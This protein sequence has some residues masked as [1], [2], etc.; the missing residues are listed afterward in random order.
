VTTSDG[1][2]LA[3]ARQPDALLQLTA[4]VEELAV[5]VNALVE[6]LS[7]PALA[8]P[9]LMT[10]AQAGAV[11]GV[12]PSWVRGEAQGGRIT[13]RRV[14]AQYRF[15]RDDVD[16]LIEKARRAGA[17]PYVR[18]AQQLAA[19]NRRRVTQPNPP[20]RQVGPHDRPRDLSPEAARFFEEHNGPLAGIVCPGS[21]QAATT[22][23]EYGWNCPSCDSTTHS[24]RRGSTVLY[25]HVKYVPAG[26]E[27]ARTGRLWP[28]KHPVDTTRS[29][30]AP[31]A[32]V[33]SPKAPQKPDFD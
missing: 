5:Q 16:E 20:P 3:G 1:R 25:R 29:E 19:M 31:A 14:G 8:A 32:P 7:A 28:G 11:L 33:T 12:S 2:R 22:S 6:H 26:S 13:H 21:G 23:G 17:D 30:A 18:S 15:T 27:E 9:P 4:Q 24:V 10:C